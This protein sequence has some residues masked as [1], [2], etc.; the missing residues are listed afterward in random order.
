MSKILFIFAYDSYKCQKLYLKKAS[1]ALHV[2]FL[3]LH[4]KKDTA[5]EFCM[6]AVC[7]QLY[8]TCSVFF[9]SE[10][11]AYF[12]FY[13]YLFLEQNFELLGRK[14]KITK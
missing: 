5:L 10:E 6:H 12:V 3:S 14:S 9:F 8:H 2:L 1:S 4:S 11:S 7:M 13:V